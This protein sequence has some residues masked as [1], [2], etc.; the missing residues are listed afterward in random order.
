MGRQDRTAQVTAVRESNEIILPGAI[1][2]HISRARL[3]AVSILNSTLSLQTA[4][5]TL[6]LEL[7]PVG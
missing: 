3:S 4:G 5:A 2:A 6:T 7:A 1:R